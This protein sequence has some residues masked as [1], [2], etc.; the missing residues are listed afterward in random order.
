MKNLEI[1]REIVFQL[2]MSWVEE[3]TESANV[4]SFLELIK[5]KVIAQI[6][7]ASHDKIFCDLILINFFGVG[8][9]FCNFSDK[10]LE[11]RVCSSSLAV[12]YR[13]AQT[14]LCKATIDDK[15]L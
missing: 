4:Q 6:S 10:A 8:I 11:V 12:S 14:C 3:M 15:E 13:K 5:K 2:T 9:F 1:E 7:Q